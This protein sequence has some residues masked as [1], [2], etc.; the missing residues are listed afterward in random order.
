MELVPL[1]IVVGEGLA[2]ILVADW[3]SGGFA[4]QAV[5][6]FPGHLKRKVLEGSV[7]EERRSEAY[8]KSYSTGCNLVSNLGRKKGMRKSLKSLLE[9]SSGI[10]ST[11]VGHLNSACYWLLRL[12]RL[13]RPSLCG[14]HDQRLCSWRVTLGVRNTAC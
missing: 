2:E 5:L 1:N 14:H 7:V 6:G 9:D 8:Q 10:P 11:W 4:F 12:L 13:L 3:R